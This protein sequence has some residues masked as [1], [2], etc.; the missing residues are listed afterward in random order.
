VNKKGWRSRVRDTN[1]FWRESTL[2]ERRTIIGSGRRLRP[3]VHVDVNS[4]TGFAY[5]FS[6]LSR[7]RSAGQCLT[8]EW[9]DQGY[10]SAKYEDT[11]RGKPKQTEQ[12]SF[13]VHYRKIW[14]TSP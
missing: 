11:S 5:L 9:L 4:L 6:R 3:R 2:T 12:W 13:T 7:E 1:A 10:L 14:H 8:R